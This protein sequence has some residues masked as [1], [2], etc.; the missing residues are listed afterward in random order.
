MMSNRERQHATPPWGPGNPQ[1]LNRFSYVNNNP[2]RYSDPSGHVYLSRTQAAEIIRQLTAIQKEINKAIRAATDPQDIMTILKQGLLQFIGSYKGVVG[3]F[4]S[5]TASILYDELVTHNLVERLTGFSDFLMEIINGLSYALGSDSPWIFMQFSSLG[6]NCGG[7]DTNC[8]F[9]GGA[10]LYIVWEGGRFT[11]D[12]VPDD[13]YEANVGVIGDCRPS[14][15]KNCNEDEPTHGTPNTA[16][17]R[18]VLP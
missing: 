16:F 8:E 15:K 13:F 6:G 7:S 17:Q 9:Q 11:I 10:S 18:I 4:I 5:N 14:N 2:L 1:E 3:A 12:G